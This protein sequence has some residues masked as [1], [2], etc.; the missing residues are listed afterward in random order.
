MELLAQNETNV[1]LMEPSKNDSV[2]A[3]EILHDF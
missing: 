3:H 1:I 2:E